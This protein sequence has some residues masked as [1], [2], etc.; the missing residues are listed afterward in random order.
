MISKSEQ[1][2]IIKQIGLEGLEQSNDTFNFR[3]PICGDSKR[4][5]SKKRGYF[6]W[7]RMKNSGYK[8]KC[9]NCGVNLSFISF[10]KKHQPDLYKRYIFDLLKNKKRQ[11]EP[12]STDI[13]EKLD[14]SEIKNF[15]NNL[16]N[17]E[18]IFNIKDC[19]KEIIEYVEQRKIPK[20]KYKNIFFIEN[21]YENLFKPLKILIKE[22]EQPDIIDNENHL[23]IDPRIFWFIKNRNNDII[24][25]Q[26]RS[27]NPKIKR[28]YLTIKLTDEPMIGNIENINLEEP[29]YITEGYIDSMFLN[30]AVSLNGSSYQSTLN[31]FKEIKT[32]N[33][34]FVFDNEPYNVEIKKKVEHVISESI[35]TNIPKIGICL[36][37]KN[38][39]DLGKDINEYIKKGIENSKLINIINENTYYG[40]TARIKLS[41]W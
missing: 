7:D 9:H 8:Y 5:S 40:L 2:I 34:I 17:E 12:E 26:G 31:L 21:F 24:G 35:K 22:I 29:V 25:I 13:I 41:K 4:D 16:F 36:L 20:N 6:Y 11:T 23:K 32:K 28:R 15:I 19:S 1:Q 14:N 33:I 37:P 10:L 27:I 39:R 30:N 38:I 3:C 18:K